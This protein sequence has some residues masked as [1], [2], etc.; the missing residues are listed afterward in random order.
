MSY[1]LNSVK[2]FAQV[3]G[4]YFN[5]GLWAAALV[6][7]WLVVRHFGNDEIAA[8]AQGD[9]TP[10]TKK[11]SESEDVAAAQPVELRVEQKQ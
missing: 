10:V 2:I 8:A 11:S 7:T 3:G 5:F 4:V 1:G 9:D 6:P